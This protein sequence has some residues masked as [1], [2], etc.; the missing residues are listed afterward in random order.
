MLNELICL[1]PWVIFKSF[2]VELLWILLWAFGFFIPFTV[3]ILVIHGRA[4][5]L[6]LNF[7]LFVLCHTQVLFIMP[8]WWHILLYS[9]LD[10]HRLTDFP[11]C[12]RRRQWD[13]RR[14]C[15]KADSH[16]T[17]FHLHHILCCSS[18]SSIL[19]LP[20]MKEPVEWFIKL[21][22]LASY[23]IQSSWYFFVCARWSN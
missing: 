18:H 1:W 11:A 21:V 5:C 16:C 14:K 6:T 17:N 10:H 9:K 3:I 23:S 12:K 13:P 4:L 22:R 15:A 20:L 8:F 7:L 2:K 19:L